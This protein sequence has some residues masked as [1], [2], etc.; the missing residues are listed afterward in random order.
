M[1]RGVVTAGQVLAVALAVIVATVGGGLLLTTVRPDYGP[2][3]PVTVSATATAAGTI[4][5]QHQGGPALTVTAI[6]VTVRVGGEPLAHQPPIPFFAATGFHGGPTGPFN[7]AADPTWSRGETASFSIADTNHP[8]LA[9]GDTVVVR[10][11][12]TGDLLAVAHTSVTGVSTSRDDRRRRPMRRPVDPMLDLG[13]PGRREHPVGFGLV[14]EQHDRVSDPAEQAVPRRVGADD[15]HVPA[16]PQ[17]PPEFRQRRHRFG[18]VLD[19][20]RRPHHVE[21]VRPVRES[22][23]VAEVERDGVVFPQPVPGPFE[24][25]DALV[26]ADD[27]IDLA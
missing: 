26:D 24:L 7:S 3:T 16:R 9:P 14:V 22:F 4:T 12:R 5:L 11:Y 8:P 1:T 13:V 23:G 15:Q 17:D 18:P 25:M 2:A 6:D 20:S 19:R 21:G 27:V 10:I